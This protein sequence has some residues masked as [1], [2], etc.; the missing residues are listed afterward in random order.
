MYYMIHD[1]IDIC[2]DKLTHWLPDNDS[3]TK[4]S[5]SKLV[6]VT[7]FQLVKSTWNIKSSGHSKSF[8][9]TDVFS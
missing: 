6:E 3:I 1:D 4:L 2:H 5:D 9:S 7:K 8:L